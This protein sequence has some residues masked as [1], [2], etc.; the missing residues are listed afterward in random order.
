MNASVI[1]AFVALAFPF[2]LLFLLFVADDQPRAQPDEFL[3]SRPVPRVRPAVRRV[4]RYGMTQ[5]GEVYSYLVRAAGE[6][7]APHQRGSGREQ[8]MKTHRC[9]SRC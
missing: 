2:L 7:A 6:R 3:A 5:E 1:R 9:C 8:R 4:V